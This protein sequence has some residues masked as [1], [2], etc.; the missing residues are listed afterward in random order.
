MLIKKIAKA[1]KMQQLGKYHNEQVSKVSGVAPLGWPAHQITCESATNQLTCEN[2]KPTHSLTGE[3][4][5]D[6]TSSKNVGPM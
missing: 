4:A 5:R 1:R 6:A 2:L 3:G